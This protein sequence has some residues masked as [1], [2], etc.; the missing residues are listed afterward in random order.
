MITLICPGCG[1]PR[2][3][4]QYLCW[5]CWDTLPNTARDKLAIRDHL[6]VARAQLLRQRLAENIP[7]HEIEINL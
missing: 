7:L 3:L 6:A 2:K 4:G 1:S 5:D